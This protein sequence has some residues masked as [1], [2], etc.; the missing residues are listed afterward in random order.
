MI[1]NHTAYL[2]TDKYYSAPEYDVYDLAKNKHLENLGEA[3]PALNTQEKWSVLMTTFTRALDNQELIEQLNTFK[4]QREEMPDSKNSLNLEQ[5]VG[6]FED[7]CFLYTTSESDYQLTPASKKMLLTAI[8]ESIGECE[9]G[10]NSQFYTVLQAYK[11]DNDWIKDELSKTRCSIIRQLQ[12]Q[13]L[14]HQQQLDNGHNVHTLNILITAAKQEQLGIN[15]QEEISDVWE[16][17]FNKRT[18]NA[19]FQEHYPTLFRSYEQQSIDTLTNYYLDEL[20]FRLDL[21]NLENLDNTDWAAGELIIPLAKTVNIQK[22]IEGHFQGLNITGVV[23]SL[24]KESDDRIN[25]ILKTKQDVAHIIKHLV[26][27]KLLIDQYCVRIDDVEENSD[28]LPDIRLQKG[29]KKDD[30]LAVYRAFEQQDQH[31]MHETLKQHVS[32]LACYPELALSQ[33]HKNPTLISAFPI[34]LKND[35]RFTDAAFSSLNKSLDEAVAQNHEQAINQLTTQLLNLIKY[36]TGYLHDLPESVRTHHLIAS[37]LPQNLPANFNW[38][39]E[40]IGIQAFM[41][42]VHQLNPALLLEI[43]EQRKQAH[44]SPLPFFE[45]DRAIHDLKTY[46]DELNTE[47]APQWDQSYLS[48]RRRA[49]N[50]EDLAYLINPHDKKN[51]A[52]YLAQTNTWFTGFTQ[53]HAYQTSFEKLWLELCLIAQACSKLAWSILITYMAYWAF[54]NITPMITL[55]I[56]PHFWLLI[57]SSLV[58]LRTASAI[59]STSLAAV[60][61]TIFLVA[62]LHWAAWLVSGL[63]VAIAVRACAGNAYPVAE[64]ICAALSTSFHDITIM[65]SSLW[66]NANRNNTLENASENMLVRLD[67]IDKASAQ[68]KSD[69]LRTLLSQVKADVSDETGH[70]FAE[71]LKHKYRIFHHGDAHEVSFSDVSRMRRSSSDEFQLEETSSCMG[72]FSGRTS[73]EALMATAEA[74]ETASI[75]LD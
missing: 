53:Y 19:F 71:L 23:D 50:Q 39:K 56:Q 7:F 52:T 68:E 37:R 13:Y 5:C 49:C 4:T 24:G 26:T 63:I 11:K 61:T 27:E 33:L 47:L 48:I 51:A 75:G 35:T 74:V 34:E 32:I 55:L 66:V 46:H 57:I 43:I 58:L 59:N 69:V 1:S 9:T 44:L 42:H 67:S 15:T 73:S 36:E 64:A 8:K 12:T 29:I 10:I 72:F 14:S 21:E 41:T 38:Q 17:L 40:R 2:P 31:V 18:I 60:A 70:T 16:F 3:Y 6:Y 65:L 62:W 45:H 25:F 22:S 30:L 28:D 20:A 54:V